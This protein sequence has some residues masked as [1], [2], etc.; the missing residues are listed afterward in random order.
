LYGGRKKEEG[1]GK[2]EDEFLSIPLAGQGYYEMV[3]RAYKLLHIRKPTA[4]GS[5]P[6]SGLVCL[7]PHPTSGYLFLVG[8]RISIYKSLLP[9]SFFLLPS[10]NR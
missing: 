10:L 6:L 3:R 5:F 1:R 8:V 7:K 2:G 4:C 9:S